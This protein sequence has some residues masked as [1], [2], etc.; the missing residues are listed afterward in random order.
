MSSTDEAKNLSPSTGTASISDRTAFRSRF[1]AVVI[2]TI[3]NVLDLGL[4]YWALSLGAR[5][6]NP[7]AIWL[8][9]TK[10]G[11]YLKLGI[12]ASLI[13]ALKWKPET[14]VMSLAGAWFAAGV[15]FLVVI[16]NSVTVGYY[17]LQH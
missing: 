9:E 13:A 15:Y 10:I 16:L 4:T 7:L 11:I 5:E 6:G 14:S 17:L 2:V 12:C 8:I 1:A 3:F